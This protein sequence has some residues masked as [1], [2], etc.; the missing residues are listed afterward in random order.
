MEAVFIAPHNF[1]D[2]YCETVWILGGLA[3]LVL[4][5]SRSGELQTVEA[6]AERLILE[7][8]SAATSGGVDA[9]GIAAGR[10]ASGD[11]TH[12]RAGSGTGADGPGHACSA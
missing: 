2:M 12:A 1:V 3:H 10:P 7:M 8:I 5:S 11:R 4:S 6:V 9:G